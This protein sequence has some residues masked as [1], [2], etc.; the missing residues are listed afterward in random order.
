MG[1]QLKAFLGNKL[2]GFYRI[3]ECTLSRGA[4]ELE[5]SA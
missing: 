5:T 4:M 1:V 2:E 3:V